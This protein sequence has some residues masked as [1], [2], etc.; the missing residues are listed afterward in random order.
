MRQTALP[1]QFVE[2]IP[3]QLEDGVLYIS[4]R[5]GTAI[6]LCCCGCGTELV[7]PL[8]PAGW[9]GALGGFRR[10]QSSRGLVTRHQM[11]YSRPSAAVQ[12]LAGMVVQ[13]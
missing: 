11:L 10:R 2:F 5:H 8:N 6:H 7:T 4:E 3:E 12:C 1:P 13:R 9:T